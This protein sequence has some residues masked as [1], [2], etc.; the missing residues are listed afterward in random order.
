MRIDQILVNLVGNALKFTKK[1]KIEVRVELASQ[2]DNKAKM[3]FAVADSGIGVKPEQRER[4]FESFTQADG[5]THRNYGGSGLGLSIAEQLVHLMGG[6]IQLDSPHDYFQTPI[7]ACF[8]FEIELEIGE[9]LSVPA[10]T[11]E[12]SKSLERARVL[13]AEDNQVNQ[14]LAK[15]VLKNI[16]CQ[17]DFANNGQ[18]CVD[19]LKAQTYDCI[20]MDIQMPIM[21]GLEATKYIRQ[22]LQIKIPI[23]GLSANVTKADIEKSMEAGMNAHIGK[24]YTEQQIYMA[25]LEQ[26]PDKTKQ[27]ALSENIKVTNINLMKDLLE[28]EEELIRGL[29]TALEQAGYYMDE[30][31]KHIE[32]EDLGQVA[33][34]CH[35]YKSSSR[36]VGAL[37]LQEALA[38]MEQEANKKN[39]KAVF[40]SL[41]QVKRLN[42]LVRAELKT[43]L[44]GLSKA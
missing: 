8:W 29:Q 33:F 18:E 20:L 4:I 23:I 43:A 42:E 3:R 41:V 13:V 26:L 36:W 16:G 25:L 34:I 1:G 17:A 38:Q 37:K 22:E 15:V 7:G 5:E 19:M 10:K 27:V 12:K 40:E 2:N 11:I 6:K 21:D 14:I 44:Q 28:T 30:I 9:G 24:P 31:E 32:K 35:T 39:Q